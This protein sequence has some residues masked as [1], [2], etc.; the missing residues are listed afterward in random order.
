MSTSSSIEV[1]TTV[2][3]INV[4]RRGY[5]WFGVVNVRI[6]EEKVS[7]LMTGSVAQWLYPGS[8]A[9]VELLDEPKSVNGVKNPGFQ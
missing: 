3:S 6:N 5:R 2:E 7:M 1:V 4:P 9:K 8:E